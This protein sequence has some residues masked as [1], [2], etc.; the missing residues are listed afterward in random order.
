MLLHVP[1]LKM[2]ENLEINTPLLGKTF[3]ENSLKKSL[4]QSKANLESS[5]SNATVTPGCDLRRFL[6]LANYGR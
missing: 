3:G 2:A 5:A 1:G 6:V 4:G